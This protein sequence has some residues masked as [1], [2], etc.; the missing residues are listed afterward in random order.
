MQKPYLQRIVN[1]KDKAMIFL[2]GYQMKYEK[3]SA[4]WADKLRQANWHGAIYQ[5]WWD[6]GSYYGMKNMSPLGNIPILNS[7]YI[8]LYPHWQVI[9][10]RAKNT[11]LTYF[12][13]LISCIPETQISLIG[14]SLGCRVIHYGMLNY[15]P[16]SKIH[17]LENIYLLA[18]AIRTIRWDE[19]AD[20]ISGKVH[21]FYNKKDFVL[22]DYFSIKGTYVYKPCGLSP[23]KSQ[24]HG[25]RNV[26]ITN[27]V[28]TQKHEL[29]ISLNTLAKLNYW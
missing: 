11:G 2:N 13:S 8:H 28:N 23:I 18:G 26:N 4:L 16:D 6:S 22:R 5:L 14:Y 7:K 12:S 15:K 10:K 24:H 29:L 20:K 1:G 19:I 27:I 3:N 9:L 25:I 21:N 17:S